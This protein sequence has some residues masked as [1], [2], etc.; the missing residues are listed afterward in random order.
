LYRIDQTGSLERGI[1]GS[2]FAEDAKKKASV[3]APPVGELAGFS[4]STYDESGTGEP[5]P[6]MN[7]I[8]IGESNIAS[9]C[10]ECG[11]NE[12]TIP[13]DAT[14]NSTV[15]CSD[16]VA[17]LGKWGDVKTAIKAAEEK[18]AKPFST[19]GVQAL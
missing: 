13:K 19:D 6:H 11:S 9:F 18:L 2:N 1:V 8:P 3:Y 4:P 7:D 12:L 5:R 16:C 17:D 14:D 15:T 10:Q